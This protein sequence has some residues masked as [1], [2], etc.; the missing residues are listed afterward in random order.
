MVQS[1]VQRSRIIA[2]GSQGRGT[3]TLQ[4]RAIGKPRRANKGQGVYRRLALHVEHCPFASI[5]DDHADC[6]A[7]IGESKMGKGEEFGEVFRRDLLTGKRALARS[8]GHAQGAPGTVRL[9][10]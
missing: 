7:E 2:T 8:F 9:L 3:R 4:R 5:A 1:T 6:L 10:Q